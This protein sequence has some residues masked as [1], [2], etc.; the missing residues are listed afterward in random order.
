MEKRTGKFGHRMSLRHKMF[1]LN[2]IS[3]LM[4]T[5]GTAI[6][7]YNISAK[8]IDNY[9]K[10]LTMDCVENFA[11]MVDP[12]Y[13][14]DLRRTLE[15]DEYQVVRAHAEETDN[16]AEVEDY[17]RKQ[18]LWEGF[19]NTRNQIDHYIET[20]DAI[21]YTYILV[22]NEHNSTTDM[23]LMDILLAMECLYH[24]NSTN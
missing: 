1:I 2:T 3:I 14:M 5:L 10:N 18:G 19:I 4:V 6:L 8:S 20:M 21:K 15:S 17:L 11:T 24:H 9:Y 22:R 23:Y 13:L 7:S 16:A 12:E